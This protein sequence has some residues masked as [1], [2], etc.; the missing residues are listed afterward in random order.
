MDLK[1]R[2]RREGGFTLIELI[3]VIIILGILAAVI[4]PKY[5]DMTEKAK[6]G[7]ANAAISE[8]VARFN[9]GYASYLLEHHTPAADFSVLVA[10]NMANA[11][12]DMGDW[13][14]GITQSGTDLSLKATESNDNATTVLTKTIKWPS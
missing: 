10:A 13:T 8:G 2:T 5:F 6:E 7:A 1:K 11:T 12:M 9:M 3:S 14:V 4:T